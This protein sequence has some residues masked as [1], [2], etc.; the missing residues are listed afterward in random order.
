MASKP[1]LSSHSIT[2]HS[3][4]GCGRSALE[5]VIRI[6]ERLGNEHQITAESVAR[7]FEVSP[8]TI[9]RDIEFMRDRIGAPIA[10]DPATHTYTYT[11]HCD[12]LPL[13]RIDADEALALALAGRT[14]AA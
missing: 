12:L 8:R 10:W 9:K 4:R 1:L 11:A 2:R 6:H 5:R 3:A 14:F 7:E 13:L